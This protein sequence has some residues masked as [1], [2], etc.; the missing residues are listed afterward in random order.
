V[1]GH[2]N[3]GRKITVRELL[4]HTSGIAN[5]TDDLTAL[6]SPEG[7]YAPGTTTTTQPNSSRW[8]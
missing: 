2:G 8:R 4:Q 5:Y 6:A 1:S 7:Y 3:D